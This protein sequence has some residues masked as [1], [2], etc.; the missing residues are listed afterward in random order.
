[1]KEPDYAALAAEAESLVR[2]VPH[3]IANLANL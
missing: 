1:M 3:P 2:D